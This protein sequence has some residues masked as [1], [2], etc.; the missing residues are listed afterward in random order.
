[1]SLKTKPIFY[2]RPSYVMNAEGKPE[3]VLIDI[4]TW[5]II[6]NYLEDIVDNHLLRQ[7]IDDLK[8][9]AEGNRPAGWQTWE[10]F[11]AELDALEQAGELPD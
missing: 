7:V 11:E 10:A 1:M 2:T 4:S 3:A 8:V 6:L 5:R 9:L